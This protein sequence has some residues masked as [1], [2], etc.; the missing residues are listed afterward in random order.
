LALIKWKDYSPQQVSK[1][2]NRLAAIY[3]VFE[4]IFALPKGIRQK[5]VDSLNLKRGD[6][7]LEIGCG[8][9]KNLPFLINAVGKEGKVYGIDVSKN[10]LKR[11]KVFAERNKW[12]NLKLTCID[13]LEFEPPKMLNGVL[14]SLSYATMINRR[15]VLK[16]VWSGLAPGGRIVIMD[17]QFPLGLPGRAMILL[18][19]AIT[20]FLKASVL[21][22][23]YIKPIEELRDI[24]KNEVFVQEISFGTYFI[25][26][27]VKD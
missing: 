19:P 25:A 12:E 20:L 13:A 6:A 16:K 10:M 17:A 23:P 22:N 11:A 9:G 8:T 15:E 2:Y 1:R 18:R 21:G 4:L 14:F 24:T 26:A 5:T 27:A 7:V 3:P